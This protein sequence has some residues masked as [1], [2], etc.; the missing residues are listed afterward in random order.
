[1]QMKLILTLNNI[2]LGY[3]VEAQNL[4][5]G[6]AQNLVQL[7]AVT[8]ENAKCKHEDDTVYGIVT[9]GTSWL[10]IAFSDHDIIS[11]SQTIYHISFDNLSICQRTLK[12]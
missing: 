6:V 5:G 1:M 11:T 9:N 4:S 12:N 10:F 7:E 8:R 3:M 2:Q